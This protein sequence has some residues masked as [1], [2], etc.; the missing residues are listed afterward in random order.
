MVV[1]LKSCFFA[2]NVSVCVCV[3]SMFYPF[4]CFPN[5]SP[6]FFKG[7]H[8]TT[9]YSTIFKGETQCQERLSSSF[10][11][12]SQ[13]YPG[14][15]GGIF[16]VSEE[17]SLDLPPPPTKDVTFLVVTVTGWPVDPKNKSN[18]GS[19]HWAA[20][21]LWSLRLSRRLVYFPAAFAAPCDV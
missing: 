7:Y 1:F 17:S 2:K 4:S 9:T 13:G 14:I 20:T 12:H 16:Q 6:M 19:S 18:P 15:A 3:F 8:C 5:K 21:N 10:L 11:P